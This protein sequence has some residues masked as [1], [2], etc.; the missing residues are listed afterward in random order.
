MKCVPFAANSVW[1]YQSWIML[2]VCI[3]AYIRICFIHLYPYVIYLQSK[4]KWYACLGFVVCLIF[5]VR[6]INMDFVWFCVCEALW[7]EKMER[8]VFL[9]AII[10]NHSVDHIYFPS[11]IKYETV[12]NNNNQVVQRNNDF[13]SWPLVIETQTNKQKAIYFIVCKRQIVIY[14][15]NNFFCALL[16]LGKW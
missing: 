12:N 4:L 13:I 9:W 8:H 6:K 15:I 11:L 5:E 16:L 7:R 3:M 2:Y 10:H 14:T 1:C